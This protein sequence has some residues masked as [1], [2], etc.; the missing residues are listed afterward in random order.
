[1]PELQIKI[2]P[3]DIEAAEERLKEEIARRLDK[4]KMTTFSYLLK[5]MQFNDVLIEIFIPLIF[6]ANKGSIAL[7][8]EKFFDEIIIRMED[9]YG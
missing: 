3:I 8:Q 1:V 9:E 4:E 7:I 5:D 2:N 6:L